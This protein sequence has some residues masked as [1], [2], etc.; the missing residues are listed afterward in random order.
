MRALENRIARLEAMRA[1]SD[2]EFIVVH[3]AAFCSDDL[4][5]ARVGRNS[6]TVIKQAANESFETFEARAIVAAKAAGD[7]WGVAITV[8]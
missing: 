7:R 1:G 5:S 4:S 2:D 8:S 6:G 3:I